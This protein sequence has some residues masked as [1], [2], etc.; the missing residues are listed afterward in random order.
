MPLERTANVQQAWAVIDAQAGRRFSVHVDPT[1]EAGVP[2][3]EIDEAKEAD[4]SLLGLPWELLHDGKAFLFQGAK[5]TRVR[6]RLPRTESFEVPVVATP[7]RTLL[8]TARPE[9]EACGYIDHRVSALPLVQAMEDLGGLVR[10]KV[11][12][13]PTL[14]ALGEELERAR[15]EHK[16]YHVVHF[17]GHGVYDRRV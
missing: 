1:P 14:A 3:E 7:I 2:D 6:R 8:G 10:L 4:T 11:L 13:P 15:N 9:D 12:R 5:P 17:D 16:P